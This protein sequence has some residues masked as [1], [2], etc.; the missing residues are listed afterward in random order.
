M[1]R[2]PATPRQAPRPGTGRTSRTG[3][4]ARG[5]GAVA[6]IIV[7]VTLAGLA[8]AVLRLSQQ[9]QVTVAQDVL[10]PLSQHY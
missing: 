7:L 5:L 9:S 8:A 6:V 1:T 2:H 3:M 4:P 10:L